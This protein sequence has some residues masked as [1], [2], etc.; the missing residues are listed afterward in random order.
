MVPADYDELDDLRQQLT[1]VGQGIADVLDELRELSRGLHPAILSEGGLDP[2]LRALARRSTVPIHLHVK[3]DDRLREPIEVAAYYVMSETLTNVAKH[4]QASAVE[5][6]VE[7]NDEFLLLAIRDDGIG[8]ADP[9]RGSGL[10]GIRDRVEALAGT[11]A[12]TSPAG[13]GTSIHV[14]LPV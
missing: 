1:R 11:I 7:A 3:A 5:V 8:G 14:E 9:E 10:I 4:A 12:V 6:R 13:W 2:A